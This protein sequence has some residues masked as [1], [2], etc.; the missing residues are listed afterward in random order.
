MAHPKRRTSKHRK[1]IRRSHL[2][3]KP[4]SI[5]SCG[6]CG[7]VGRPHTVCENCGHYGFE[8]G[9]EKRGHEVL[10]REEF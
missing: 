6:R 5:S 4:V 3:L 8:K 10:A 1:G 7:A 9:D 2:A